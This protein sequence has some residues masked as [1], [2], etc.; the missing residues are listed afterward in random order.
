MEHVKESTGEL[1][2]S[3]E[4][5][6]PPVELKAINITRT[7]EILKKED[8]PI[9]KELC[10]AQGIDPPDI[11]KLFGSFALKENGKIIGIFAVEA[12]ATAF[13]VLDP[14]ASR[15]VRVGALSI[16]E[17]LLSKVAMKANFSKLFAITREPLKNILIK[18]FRYE[19]ENG[20]VLRLDL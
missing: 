3:R 9:L 6:T 20:S 2:L 14:T 10:D 15:R 8:L 19:E 16:M 5:A 13:M 17:G 18:H 1:S 4:P 7:V 12:L 11:S